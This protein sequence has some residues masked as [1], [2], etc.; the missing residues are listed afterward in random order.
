MELNRRTF[1]KRTGTIAVSTFAGRLVLDA[2]G[3]LG[4]A[5]GASLPS[6]GTLPA[7]TPILVVIDLQGGNDA[8]NTVVPIT[9]PWYYSAQYGH[10]SLAIPANSSLKL[11][12]SPYGLHPSLTWVADRWANV[13]DVAIVQGVGENVMHEFSH[14]T[15]SHYRH[16]GHFNGGT[17]GRGWLG[18]YND[19]QAASSPLA[20]VSLSG[21]H[22][23]LLGGQTPVLSVPD[24][25][26]FQFGTD[27]RWRTGFVESLQAMGNAPGAA[28]MTKKAAQNVA[29]TFAAKTQVNAASK[30]A[31]AKGGSGVIAQLS[32]AAM[33]IQAGI[34]SQTY[35][36]SMG[37][38]D[39]HGSESWVHGD[40][41]RQLNE[42]LQWFFGIIDGGSRK[43]DVFVLIS[44][45]FGRQ[46]T[47]NAG[48]G[49][50]HG[51][52]SNDLLIGGGVKGGLYGI[53]PNMDPGGPTRP[54]RINDALV[55]TVDFREVYASILNRLGGDPNMTEALLFGTFADLGCF[56]P[57]APQGG[58]SWSSP[59]T[60][61]PPQGSTTS[62]TMPMT[63]GPTTSTTMPMT[64]GPTTSTT[65]PMMT[66]T[67]TMRR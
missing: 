3:P 37:G 65:M 8:L 44:S 32:Q 66:T 11:N 15:A 60:T 24:C 9:D 45:E 26:G 49:C 23:M 43:N 18:R 10:G 22:P 36:V 12:S 14:F 7:G 52:A 33:L 63:P 67:T 27:W 51:Q 56:G 64:P 35:V 13:G 25:A 34:P 1:L 58:G 53:P 30:P 31:Y 5:A 62:T 29:D 59:S 41:L 39:T 19:L 21:L 42:A 55:P 4:A 48:G 46:V 38:F 47:Q 17:E 54:N 50:D 28:G 6:S 16:V 57:A 61:A 40:L 20:S 2:F